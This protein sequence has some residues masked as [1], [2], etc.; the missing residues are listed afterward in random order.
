MPNKAQNTRRRE[1]QAEAARRR[2]QSEQDKRKARRERDERIESFERYCQ[3]QRTREIEPTP[4]EAKPPSLVVPE[5]RPSSI[6][7][8]PVMEARSDKFMQNIAQ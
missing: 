6:L 1:N 2:A 4:L 8:N 7:Q 3:Q 5:S